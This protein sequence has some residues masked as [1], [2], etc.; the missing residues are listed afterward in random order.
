MVKQNSRR[1]T[2]SV[3]FALFIHCIVF[4]GIQYGIG[5]HPEELPE[6]SGPITVTLYDSSRAMSMRQEAAE[7]QVENETVLPESKPVQYKEYKTVYGTESVITSQ[8]A[9]QEK[10]AGPPLQKAQGTL[11]EEQQF[12]D[13]QGV[14]DEVRDLTAGAPA[15]EPAAEGAGDHEKGVVAESVMP[16]EEETSKD[17]F[18]FPPLEEEKEQPLAFDLERLDQA[19]EKSKTSGPVASE[20]ETADE[21][22]IEA[23]APGTEL[24]EIIWDDAKS[25]RKLLSPA[26]KPEIPEWVKREGLDLT[27]KVS[28]EVTPQGHTVLIRVKKSSGYSDVDASILEA[29][30]KL[31]FN[32]IRE[33]KNVRGTVSYIISTR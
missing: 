27:V 28:F 14:T 8:M 31:R 11:A 13:T 9:Q 17:R 12:L 24:T 3:F 21:L 29:V 33:Q 20:R 7:V 30:R 26:G 10:A 4:I 2:V 15:R 6:Y 23:G 19:L 32:P 5:L 25:G 18:V 16:G 1:I 22:Q